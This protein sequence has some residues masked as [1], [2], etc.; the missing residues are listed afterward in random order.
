LK[1]GKTQGSSLSLHGYLEAQNK[2]CPQ[3]NPIHMQCSSFRIYVNG[4]VYMFYFCFYRKSCTINCNSSRTIAKRE[5]QSM[6][7]IG[8]FIN[9]E[10]VPDNQPT[11]SL[12]CENKIAMFLILCLLF[13]TTFLRMYCSSIASG[14]CSYCS[15]RSRKRGNVES[16]VII[17]D[18]DIGIGV[19]VCTRKLNTRAAFTTGSGDAQLST[20]DV[21]LSRI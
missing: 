19:L 5:R 4:R 7:L 20:A 6:F 18:I 12:T 8:K 9:Q 17:W 3:D 11:A 2:S 16:V 21:K 10:H 15:A 13:T 1:V 14:A